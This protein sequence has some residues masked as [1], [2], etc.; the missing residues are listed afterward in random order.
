MQI[1]D[2]TKEWLP[3]A[4]ALALENY[5]EERAA[6]PELPENP[7]LPPLEH[8]AENG[9]GAAAI[10]NGRLLGFLGGFLPFGPVF[11]TPDTMGTWSPLHAH[12]VQ[13]ENRVKIWQRLYQ[14]AAEKWAKAGTASHAITLYTHD[15]DAQKALFLYGFGARCADLIRPL[16]DLHSPVQS[17]IRF[18]ELPA[19]RSVQLRPLRRAL[20]DHLGKSPSFMLHTEDAMDAYLDRKEKQASRMFV[21]FD[22]DAPIAYMEFENKGESFISWTPGTANICGAYCLPEHRGTG[23]VQALLDHMIRTIRQEGYIR[24]GVDCETFN[25]TAINFWGKHFSQYTTSVVRRIDE[26][27]VFH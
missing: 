16:T 4:E 13:K 10:E 11:C 8:F 24:L 14:A 27:S 9:M 5:R 21:A 22:G 19:E 3:Q 6:V 23:T 17:N 18:G 12:A 25:P 26:N 2:F 15:I 7:A 20:A 1:I